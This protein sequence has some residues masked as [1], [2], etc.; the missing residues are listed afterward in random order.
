MLTQ[1]YIPRRKSGGW[2]G[3]IDFLSIRASCSQIA[4]MNRLPVGYKS[5]ITT[6]L[7]D[8]AGIYALFSGAYAPSCI[9]HI[10]TSDHSRRCL[11]TSI[12]YIY[13]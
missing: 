3:L 2:L 11:Y 10:Y 1:Q 6:P 4:A 8:L 13:V 9:V 5:F 12:I 7:R